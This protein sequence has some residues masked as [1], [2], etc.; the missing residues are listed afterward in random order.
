MWAGV[1]MLA[2]AVAVGGP[3][4]V[5][6]MLSVPVGLSGMESGMRLA[7]QAQWLLTGLTLVAIWALGSLVL[8][9]HFQGAHD[10]AAGLALIFLRILMAFVVLRLLGSAALPL[11][12][13]GS[14]VGGLALIATG[15]PQALVELAFLICADRY[16]SRSAEAVF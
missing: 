5:V 16:L 9:V 13:A 3:G 8:V 7:L 14:M 11:A 2:F 12:A 15:A 4:M 10:R 1:L 6:D